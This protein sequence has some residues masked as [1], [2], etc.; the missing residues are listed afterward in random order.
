MWSVESM[1]A[2]IEPKRQQW[3]PG[4]IVE[5]ALD[6]GSWAYA[7]MLTFPEFA[8]FESS[9][10]RLDS[11]ADFTALHVVFRLW[12]HKDAYTTGRWRKTTRTSISQELSRSVPRFKQYSSGQLARYQ[13]ETESP[14]SPGEC[15]GLECAA[16]W[17]PIQ[18]EERL[19]D[20]RDGRTN[21]I[22]EGLRERAGIPV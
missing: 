14:A 3:T 22:V 2:Q 9:G 10:Q 5:I 16:V 6:R 8:F 1:K 13:D 12:V 19:Q 18:V 21:R 17:E 11:S 7:Q 4:A 20:H 15:K